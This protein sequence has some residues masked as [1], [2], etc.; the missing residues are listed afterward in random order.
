MG[1]LWGAS[2]V[3]AG[4][5]IRRDVSVPAGLWPQ[6]SGDVNCCCAPVV[7]PVRP[8][9]ATCPVLLLI[10]SSLSSQ[11]P[12]HCCAT[13]HIPTDLLY[14]FLRVRLEN[15][16]DFWKSCVQIVDFCEDSNNSFSHPKVMEPFLEF[17][18][19]CFT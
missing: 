3:D 9:C 15:C 10:W 1:F 18:E 2:I 8:N 7:G 5:F 11:P 14:L 12:C 19:G 17:I 13:C 6:P 16:Q 4:Y